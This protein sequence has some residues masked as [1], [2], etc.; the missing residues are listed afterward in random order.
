MGAGRL[1]CLRSR[2]W[3]FIAPSPALAPRFRKISAGLFSRVSLIAKGNG[4]DECYGYA[5][6]R[7][8]LKAERSYT[9]RVRLVA[10]G[11]DYIEHHVVHGLYGPSYSGGLF[12]LRSEGA[13]L[14]GEERIAGPERAMEAELRVYFRYS[15]RGRVTWKEISLEEREPIPPRLATFACREGRVPE[16]ATLAYWGEWLDRAGRRQPDIALLPEA[17]DGVS[18]G[19]AQP[20]DGPAAA[21]LAAKARQWNM[22]TCG[23]VYE[24]HGDLV[25]NVA[26]L[27]DRSGQLVGKY[28]KFLPYEPELDSGLS[29]GKELR[30]FDTDFARIGIMI[31]YDSWFPEVAKALARMGAEAILL[32]NAGYS[33]ELMPARAA[34]NGVC[35]AAS[36]LLHPA[37]IWG[38]SGERAGETVTPDSRE[39]PS[40][41]QS[42]E[43]DCASGLLVAT[44][45][46]SKKYSPHWKG[47]PMASAPAARDGRVTSL[48]PL[49]GFEFGPGRGR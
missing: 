20:A 29:P 45:D 46:L 15:A 16:A 28:E 34:D 43:H 21:L 40:A 14:V 19:A 39:S 27:F 25:H 41:I 5:R 49:K 31:C 35:I 3:Q 11:I 9:L 47:G 42:A 23:T 1:D 18:P 7:V 4:R 2:K 26:H 12:S 30:V 8:Q 17:F 48:R 32:P 33:E 13:F 44:V 38:S 6:F 36:S 37:G 24:A 22:Y 10:E